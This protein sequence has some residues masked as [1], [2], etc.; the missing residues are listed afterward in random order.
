M[1]QL[2][3]NEMKTKKL[4]IQMI[5]M[6]IIFTLLYFIL[7]YLNMSYIEM[8]NSYGIGLVIANILLNIL[9]A[10]IS[11]LMLGMSTAMIIT[12]QG[13]GRGS[14]LSFISILFG[15]LTYGCT[16]CVIAFF[17]SIGIAFSVAVLPMAGLPYKLI[18]LLLLAFGLYW[19]TRE[20]KKGFCKI[21]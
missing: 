15:V 2:V 16:S 7:D 5:V 6:F 11:T 21:K 1:M 20:I 19:V 3:F 9:M 12:R 10:N 8:K 18:S 14:N 13:S 4:I 17:A